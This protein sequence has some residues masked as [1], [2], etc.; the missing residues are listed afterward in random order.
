MTNRVSVE[1]IHAI[2]ETD[3]SNDDVISAIS[4]ANEMISALGLSAHGVAETTLTIIEQLLAAHFCALK[5]PRARKEAIAGEVSVTY[6]GK[7]GMGLKS[8]HYGQNALAI[9]WSGALASAGQKRASLSNI[10]SAYDEFN[11]SAS[12]A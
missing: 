5:D 9:D 3:L 12:T 1:D 8:T 2:F 7:D 10:F 6:Q 11:V 4:I